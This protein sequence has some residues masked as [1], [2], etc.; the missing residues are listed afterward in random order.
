MNLTA[1][2]QQQITFLPTRDLEANQHF[3]Q[4]LLG[5]PLVR[6]QGACRIYRTAPN[7]YLGFCSHL[8]PTPL[9]ASVILTLVCDAVDECFAQL[10]ALG[11]GI[12]KAPGLNERF[13]IYQCMLRD[14]DGYRVEIQRFL[15]PPDEK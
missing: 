10:T 4:Q 5:L 2:I 7:A 11:A 6:D 9:P 15:D 12:E 3:Y 14:P 8:A 13:G 1:G